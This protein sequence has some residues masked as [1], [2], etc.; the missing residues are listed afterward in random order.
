MLNI[1]KV[2]EYSIASEHWLSKK[3]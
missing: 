1:R 3:I 2:K